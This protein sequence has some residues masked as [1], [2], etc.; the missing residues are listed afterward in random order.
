VKFF[1]VLCRH[2]IALNFAMEGVFAGLN[3]CGLR[4]DFELVFKQRSKVMLLLIRR[5]DPIPGDL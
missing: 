2:P 3:N 1:G 4:W 5:A